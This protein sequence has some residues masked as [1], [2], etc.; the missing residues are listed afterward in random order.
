MKV[1]IAMGEFGWEP[2]T[3]ILGVFSTY[4]KAKVVADNNKGNYESVGVYETI[5]DSEVVNEIKINHAGMGGVG[6]LKI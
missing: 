2:G 3:E 6:T 1:F 5:I 4:G